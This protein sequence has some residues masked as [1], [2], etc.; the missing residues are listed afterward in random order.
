MNLK[1]LVIF[2]VAFCSFSA[3]T[4]VINK[5]YYFETYYKAS[6]YKAFMAC[7]KLG[8]ELLSIDSVEE[9]DK[10]H[11]LVKEKM[12]YR[13]GLTIW[14]AGAMKDVGEFN[15]MNTG[16]PV[17]STRWHQGEPN[18]DGGN[19]HCLQIWIN[20]NRFLLDDTQC[21]NERFFICQS[22]KT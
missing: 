17:L 18:N 14:T 1:L 13:N 10:I 4:Y 6:W 9:F 2:L 5:L 19:S 3:P 11:T 15:W 7:S 21:S 22:Y 20:N 8:M 12:E 16:N